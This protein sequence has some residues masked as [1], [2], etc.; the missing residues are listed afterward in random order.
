VAAVLAATLS[1]TTVGAGAE[2]TTTIVDNGPALNRVDIAVVGDGYTA[3]QMA[4]YHTDVQNMINGMFLQTPFS[5]YSTY[6]NV[7]RIDVVSNQSG[8]DH[9]ERSPAVF[10]DTAFDAAY[11]CSGIQRLICVDTFA[12]QSVV[13]ANLTPAESELIVVVVNDPEYGGSGGQVA[14]ASTN[15]SVIELVLHELGHSFGLLTDEYG[16]GPNNPSCLPGEPSAV[17]A[18]RATTRPTIKW[19]YW[20]DPA[21]PIPTTSTAAGV[22]GLYEGAAYCDTGIYRPT[23]NSKMRTLG[24]PFEQINSEQLVKR[25]YSYVSP[26]D[27]TAPAGTQVPYVAGGSQLF[28]VSHLAPTSHSLSVAWFLDGV[29]VGSADTY[30]LNFSGVGPGSHLVRVV[31]SDPTTLVRNDP[32]GLLTEARDWTVAGK[33]SHPADFDGNGSTDLS[34]YR[35][36]TGQWLVQGQSP[37]SFGLSGDVPVPCDYDG[38]GDTD[39]AVFRPTGGGWY[40]QGQAPV[41]FGLSGDKPV[42][43]DYDGDG[44]CDMAVYRPSVGGWYAVGQTTQ[45]LGVSGD[46]PVPGNYLSGGTATRAVFRPSVGGWYVQGQSPVFL[47]LNNDIPVPGDYDGNGTTDVSVFRPTVGGWYRSGVAPVF[48]GLSGDIPVPGDYDNSGSIDVATF[49]PSTGA[50]YRVGQSAVFFGVNGDRPL[51]LPSAIRQVFFP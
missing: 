3:G 50:W 39:I 46:I 30:T 51:P 15:V 48:L 49:R 40:V 26:I 19:N 1:A 45:F 31:V 23:Y 18:T 42:P 13:S 12:V 24:P 10:V 11:N 36:S 41:F 22:P 16:A 44:H 35:P 25:T 29:Q 47:G 20:I 32:T 6:Y 2:P 33:P 38:D 9:P 14:V 4:Q 28:S 34:V 37:V 43:A 5:Q 7:H 21:T 17:D 27:A 8:A